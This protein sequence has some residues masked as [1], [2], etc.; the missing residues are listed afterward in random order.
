M[1]E[2]DKSSIRRWNSPIMWVFHRDCTMVFSC[3][4]SNGFLGVVSWRIYLDLKWFPEHE[5][6]CFLI[7]SHSSKTL[8]YWQSS[9]QFFI[10]SFS[11][12][13]CQN[14]LLC[15]YCPCTTKVLA[16]QVCLSQLNFK[17]WSILYLSL[18]VNDLYF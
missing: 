13:Q 2:P 10:I 15:D 8:Q 14:A 7:S 1:F 17:T 4:D 11:T 9:G 5:L 18:F 6:F 3:W 12:F 16:R